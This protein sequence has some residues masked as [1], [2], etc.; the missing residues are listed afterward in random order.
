MNALTGQRMTRI[1]DEAAFADLLPFLANV[2]A[3]RSIARDPP[4]CAP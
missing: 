1:A 3:I 2:K 4:A